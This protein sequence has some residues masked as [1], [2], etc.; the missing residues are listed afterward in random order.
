MPS[1]YDCW[2]E[3]YDSLYEAAF[4]HAYQ[5]LTRQHLEML[6]PLLGESGHLLDVGA[7]TGRLSVPV[8]EQGHRVSAVEPSSGMLA[9]LEA[10]A[11][12]AAA[13]QRIHVFGCR[14]Q[15]VQARHGVPTDHDAAICVFSTLHHFTDR[16]ALHG[17]LMRMRDSVRR[18]GCVLL[19][20]HPPDVFEAFAAG[21]TQ[22][23]LLPKAG[24]MVR[25]MQ[26]A[27]DTARADGILDTRSEIILPDGTRILDRLAIQP[28]TLDQVSAVAHELGLAR[29]GEPCF[30]GS[31]HVQVFRKPH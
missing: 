15:D 12:Q 23:V 22:D 13:S 27:Q 8:A 28:W 9:R 20:V 6:Q 16:Q 21:R 18:G 11:R 29:V 26:C 19:G 25:W 10:K 24:G 3:L 2:A 30:I 17:S 7:G 31:E 14:M 5:A 4:G 1:G